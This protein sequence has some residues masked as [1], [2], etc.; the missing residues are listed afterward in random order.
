M[1]G[2]DHK[3]FLSVMTVPNHMIMTQQFL[4]CRRQETCLRFAYNQS[5]LAIFNNVC[6]VNK[7]V[8]LE[9]D[10]QKNK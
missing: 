2:L 5:S 6:D 10:L 3:I 8:S 4:S 7:K 9:I 1:L